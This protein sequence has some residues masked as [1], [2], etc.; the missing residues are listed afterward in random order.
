[1]VKV[2]HR[3]EKADHTKGRVTG[4][5]QPREL[6]SQP[7]IL[8]PDLLEEEKEGEALGYHRLSMFF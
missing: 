4:N 5:A 3:A 6:S 2:S 1:M 7:L 8:E